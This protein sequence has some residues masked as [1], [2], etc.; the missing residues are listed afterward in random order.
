M[1]IAKFHASEWQGVLYT[2]GGGSLFLSDLLTVSGASGTVL[3]ARVP[4]ATT[5]LADVV[6][7]TPEQ[8]CSSRTA[9]MLAMRAFLDAK[10]LSDETNLFGL[11]LT[12]SL[13]TN[14]RKRGELRAYVAVQTASR[15]QC[16][17]IRFTTETSRMEQERQLSDIA[18]E[19][20]CVAVGVDDKPMHDE[21]DSFCIASQ[22]VR[23]LLEEKLCFV[24]T[25]KTAFLPGAFDPIHEGH[26]RMKEVAERTLGVPVQYE[27]CVR[28]VDKVPLDFLEIESRRSQFNAEDLIISNAPRFVD[29]ARL[30]A[31]RGNATFVMGADTLRRLVDPDYYSGA[32]GLEEAIEFFLKRKDRF[33]VLG[34]VNE[35]K[36]FSTL[37]EVD[38]PS[39]LRELCIG[40][41]ESEFRSDL[42]STELRKQASDR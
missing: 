13:A 5:A 36:E 33:L 11:G 6:G 39:K 32:A 37:D 30:F 10:G 41:A 2:T 24:G 14:R 31:P 15:T 23:G 18:F 34:R 9:R 7:S 29:K 17:K 40:V 35:E 3:D 20:L 4:Y 42:S 1:D 12:A 27:L 19:K 28:N 22:E 26:L 8:A 38:V 25:P 21:W 16:T